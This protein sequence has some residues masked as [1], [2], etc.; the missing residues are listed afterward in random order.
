MPTLDTDPKIYLL[1]RL[2]IFGRALIL[3]V[4]Q[5]SKEGLVAHLPQFF[6]NVYETWMANSNRSLT[7]TVKYSRLTLPCPSW[8][9]LVCCGWMFLHKC[10]LL[11]IPRRCSLSQP[12]IRHCALFCP[13]ACSSPRWRNL[14]CVTYCEANQ[15]CHWSALHVLVIA[16]QQM[17]IR[18]SPMTMTLSMSNKRYSFQW[19]SIK[20]HW[21]GW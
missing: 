3:D 6:P 7:W 20:W 2:G 18:G 14:L 11:S 1:L 9:M 5:H 4:Y 12:D 17:V 13:P 15:R 10:P 8:S 21:W 16:G 19:F